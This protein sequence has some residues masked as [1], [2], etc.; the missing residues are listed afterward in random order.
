MNNLSTCHPEIQ[1]LD[2]YLKH[3]PDLAQTLAI[4]YKQQL[5]NVLGEYQKLQAEYMRLKAERKSPSAFPV[6][7]FILSFITSIKITRFTLIRRR[8]S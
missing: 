1:E 4:E 6:S 2:Q 7:T 8:K 5:I 3:H